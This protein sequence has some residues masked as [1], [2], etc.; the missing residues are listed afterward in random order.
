[1]RLSLLHD[2]RRC[3]LAGRRRVVI[4]INVDYSM[5]WDTSGLVITVHS[6]QRRID[7]ERRVESE[8]IG[9]GMGT[10]VQKPRRGV[11]FSF[12]LDPCMAAIAPLLR[13]C[14]PSL[15]DSSAMKS[16]LGA[17]GPRRAR[18]YPGTGTSTTATLTRPTADA[19]TRL[20][21]ISP[22]TTRTSHFHSHHSPLARSHFAPKLPNCPA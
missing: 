19:T 22:L 3:G 1:M 21:F 6:R 8:R 16:S 15:A 17:S 5:R 11:F 18:K 12:L 2:T 10:H 4:A 7:E 9:R 20:S 13:W 14:C